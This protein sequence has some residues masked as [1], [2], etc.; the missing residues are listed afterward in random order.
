MGK[1]V[2]LQ[3]PSNVTTTVG[4]PTISIGVLSGINEKEEREEEEEER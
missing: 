2:H 4:R 3:S 1:R